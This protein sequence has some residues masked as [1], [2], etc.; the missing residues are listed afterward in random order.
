MAAL[1]GMPAVRWP[2]TARSTSPTARPWLPVAFSAYDPAQRAP[3][4]TQ[5]AA[6]GGVKSRG[7]T[8]ADELDDGGAVLLAVA[9]GYPERALAVEPDRRHGRPGVCPAAARSARRPCG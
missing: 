2:F 6:A 1:K 9:P 3:G 8:F 5:L 4:Q 7:R